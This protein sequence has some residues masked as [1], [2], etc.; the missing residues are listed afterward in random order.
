MAMIS[1]NTNSLA[2]YQPSQERP[3]DRKRAM[4]LFRR[5]GH[6][7]SLSEIN[8]AL[9]KDP[10]QLIDELVDQALS[11][12]SITPPPW[13]Q[14]TLLDFDAFDSQLDEFFILEAAMD[15]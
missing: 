7:A 9:Q 10:A 1:C 14:Y 6:S 8:D 3:W 13:A 15:P 11:Q 5:M 4:H 12:P 2:V